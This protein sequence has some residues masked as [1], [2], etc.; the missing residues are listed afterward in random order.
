MRGSIHHAG[1]QQKRFRRLTRHGRWRSIEAMKTLILMRHA[2]SSWSEPGLDDHDRPL[3]ARGK[4]AAPV[5]ARWLAA[6]ALVPDVVLCST[7]KRA[8]QTVKRMRDA[9]PALPEPELLPGLYHAMPG[10]IMAQLRNLPPTARCVMVV[11]HQ[12]GL[13]ATAARLADGS[14]PPDCAAAFGH[15][16]TAA[17]AVLELGEGSWR[18]I[19]WGRA[20]FRR[21][22]RPKDLMAT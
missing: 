3:N 16:P 10:Q 2:K 5:M 7:A 8:R 6:Q 12:P 1:P 19:G 17:V 21:F 4:A 13:G 14:E 11:A 9:V 15:F 18:A 22:A 20:A